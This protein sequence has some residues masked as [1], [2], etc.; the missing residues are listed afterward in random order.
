MKGRKR[1]VPNLKYFFLKR[2]RFGFFVFDAD[3]FDRN[4]LSRKQ[5]SRRKKEQT[6]DTCQESRNY[7][8]AFGA[9]LRCETNF[10][11]SCFDGRADRR[12]K[13][14]AVRKSKKT[15]A[16]IKKVSR[17]SGKSGE[18][19]LGRG[20]SIVYANEEKIKFCFGGDDGEGRGRRLSS[21]ARKRNWNSV[22]GLRRWI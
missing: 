2:Q 7:T 11:S 14:A 13:A 21:A 18:L 8:S 19:C 17:G 16:V 22:K 5:N 9:L 1:S 10:L 4:G 20:C 15:G 12:M 6:K 3:S